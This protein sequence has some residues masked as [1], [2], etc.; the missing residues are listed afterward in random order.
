M[1]FTLYNN[2]QYIHT[3]IF[4]PFLKQCERITDKIWINLT[5]KELRDKG[6]DY[7][8]NTLPIKEFLIRED[9]VGIF[10]A[11]MVDAAYR[12]FD[13]DGNG[14]VSREECGI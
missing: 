7:D 1:C 12:M 10:P 8:K 6:I 14:D 11:A 5:I 2:I 3:F 9:F 4:F 13:K